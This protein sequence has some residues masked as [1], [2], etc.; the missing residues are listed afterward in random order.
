MVC[1]AKI[2]WTFIQ[3]TFECHGFW[4]CIAFNEKDKCPKGTPIEC[5]LFEYV[6][7]RHWCDWSAISGIAAETEA[8]PFDPPFPL[9]RRTQFL[10]QKIDR[11]KKE[12]I[13]NY[14]IQSNLTFGVVLRCDSLMARCQATR[15][16]YHSLAFVRLSV[17][18]NH[19]SSRHTHTRARER[20]Y[21]H[22][23]GT[24]CGRAA[25][26]TRQ[27]MVNSHTLLYD[28]T[29]PCVRRLSRWMCKCRDEAAIL[30]I[31][32]TLC[33]R[34]KF[35]SQLPVEIE[36]LLVLWRTVCSHRVGSSLLSFSRTCVLHLVHS[37]SPPPYS[38]CCRVFCRRRRHRC[39]FNSTTVSCAAA[40]GVRSLFPFIFVHLFRVF[41]CFNIF[42]VRNIKRDTSGDSARNNYA[43][44]RMLFL[45]WAL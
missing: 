15:E 35:N 21:T 29:V 22:T 1:K 36:Y 32:Y 41:E 12:I 39:R 18:V 11:N 37:L 5:E 6:A 25:A 44:T 38:S 30:C 13:V 23:Y 34:N 27:K 7:Q 8:F 14:P 9:L 4:H 28:V 42:G 20:I 3:S 43:H 33:M 16:F 31:R 26:S 40:A 45:G 10:R 19:S 24:W 17:S 2:K